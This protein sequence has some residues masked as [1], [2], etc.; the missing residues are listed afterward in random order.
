[1]AS[2]LQ[3]PNKCFGAFIG[4]K[5]FEQRILDLNGNNVS[6]IK[7][8]LNQPNGKKL[9]KCIT[10]NKESFYNDRNCASEQCYFCQIPTKNIYTMRGKISLFDIDRFYF[11]GMSDKYI[12]IRGFERTI[13][14]YNDTW[15]F[16]SSTL[17]D[18]SNGLQPPVGL[19]IWN[20]SQNNF[21]YFKF[22]QCNFEEFTCH[23]FGNCI[24]I[25]KRCDGH[26]D[27][28]FDG[29]DELG[30]KL[31][32]FKK[33]YNQKYPPRRT[34]TVVNMEVDIENI[35][36]I[37][38]LESYFNVRLK[39]SLFWFDKRITFKNLKPNG[40]QNLLDKSD[41]ENIWLPEVVFSNSNNKE[42]IKAGH[43]D[44]WSV[45]VVRLGSPKPNPVYEIDEDHLYSGQKNP[46][47]LSV[48]IQV[49]LIC[50]FDLG[51][52]PFDTQKCP[53]IIEVPYEYFK[54]FEL[55]LHDYQIAT[56]MRLAQYELL[57]IENRTLEAKTRVSI[58]VKLRRIPTYHMTATY[59]P[60]LCLIII[61]ELALFI[62]VSHFEATIMLTLTTML[63]MYTL[64][65]SLSE[66]LP[67]T[68]YLKMI[69]I[70]LFSGLVL[71]FIIICILIA[72]DSM[73]LNENNQVISVRNK[74]KR[75]NSKHI[76]K[77]MQI[78]IPT[79]TIIL[80]QFYCII[81]LYNYYYHF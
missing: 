36:D 12:E 75:W 60:T 63:V 54:Q 38:E 49:K 4:A 8:G 32:T 69:D 21:Q 46:L 23:I 59:I 14:T 47:W 20:N 68:A 10:I 43:G 71:P 30:C 39:V 22:T 53:I 37:H 1:M 51:M 24:P 6:F 58:I 29:A 11:V 40:T 80:C 2:L 9:Q 77:L 15:K 74:T 26:P 57:D 19:K 17:K 34:S 45:A 78:S 66:N 3:K 31:M 41:I 7:W 70:W 67:Q 33:G 55:K 44:D 18:K 28:V 61:T 48:S 72:L 27:C 13:C 81:A 16:S 65:Q 62:D 56:N 50:E 64:Y 35:Y 79:L 73:V 25:A 5:K 76:M 52:Y 42:R